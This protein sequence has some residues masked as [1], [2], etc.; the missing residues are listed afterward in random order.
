MKHKPGTIYLDKQLL[1][2]DTYFDTA[3][4]LEI[5]VEPLYRPDPMRYLTQTQVYIR[6]WRPSSYIVEPTQEVVLNH[7]CTMPAELQFK[8]SDNK[9]ARIVPIVNIIQISQLSGIPND[10]V[11]FAKVWI[12]IY[13]SCMTS[14]ASCTQLVR[15]E[16]AS[17]ETI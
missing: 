14:L 8:V 6:W 17:L 11:L 16:C 1:D 3:L 13:M 12:S 9:P 2:Y 7:M 4:A 5:Y 10:Q 15:C